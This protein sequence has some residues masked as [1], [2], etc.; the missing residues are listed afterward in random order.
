MADAN[1]ELKQIAIQVAN[2]LQGR[3][4]SLRKEISD[5]KLQVAELEA[6]LK[7]LA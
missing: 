6:R 1:T 5:A 2:E 3:D 7:L 4:L